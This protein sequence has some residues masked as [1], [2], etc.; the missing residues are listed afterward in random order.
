[1]VFVISK[2]LV[3]ESSVCNSLIM[4]SIKPNACVTSARQCLADHLWTVIVSLL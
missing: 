3:E 1:M 2:G 4:M